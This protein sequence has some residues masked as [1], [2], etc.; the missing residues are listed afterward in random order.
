MAL[1]ITLQARGGAMNRPAS[2]HDLRPSERLF[3]DAMTSLGYGRL[4]QIRVSGGEIVLTPPPLT[5]RCV[6]FGSDRLQIEKLPSQFE[7][8]K[9]LAEFFEQVR[10]IEEGE[11]RLLEVRAGLPFAMELRPDVTRSRCD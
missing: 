10:Q 9:Q 5:I 1:E 7:L 4:E 3:A 8:K 2:T 6:K 11:I